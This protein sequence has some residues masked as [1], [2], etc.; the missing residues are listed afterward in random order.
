MTPVVFTD[1][2]G[3]L[4]NSHDY[5]C[6]EAIPTLTLLQHQNIPIIPVTSKTRAE[7]EPLLKDLHLQGPFIVENGS[8]VFIHPDDERFDLSDTQPQQGYRLKQFGCSYPQ[9]RSALSQLSQHLDLTLQ[10]F[11]DLTVPQL[12]A[13]TGLAP[14]AAQQAQTRDF[15]EPFITPRDRPHQTIQQAVSDLGFRIVV[16]DRFS[17]LIGPQA[18]KG[19][20]VRW[21]LQQFHHSPPP[22]PILGLGN[23]PNDLDLLEAVEVPIIIP[24]NK[25]LIHPGLQHL[26]AQIAPHAGARGWAAAIAPWLAP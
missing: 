1:L 20:A 18:S 7:V 14:H 24:N 25:G 6:D 26:D 10:G 19:T 4:L 13:L 5:R 22:Q 3:T 2:D 23:S 21:L 8:G 12:T 17:H 9:A 15:S 16:G 11:G